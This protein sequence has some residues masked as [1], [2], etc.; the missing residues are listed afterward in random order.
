MVRQH[1]AGD[2]AGC[3]RMITRKN[4]ANFMNTIIDARDFHD[5]LPSNFP[6]FVVD[7]LNDDSGADTR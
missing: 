7:L 4:A 6:G 1:G 3:T 2:S 5:L